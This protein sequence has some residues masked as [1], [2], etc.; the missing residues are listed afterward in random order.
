[1]DDYVTNQDKKILERSGAS[2]LSEEVKR[3]RWKFIDHILRQDP[4]NDSNVALSLAPEGKR[5]RGRP[6]IPGGVPYGWKR[7]ERG[8]DSSC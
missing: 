2:T 1:M 8:K 5:K 4:N 7:L 6:K 3:R